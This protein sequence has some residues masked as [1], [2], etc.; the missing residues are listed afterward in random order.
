MYVDAAH[1]YRPSIMPTLLYRAWQPLLLRS[2]VNLAAI[3]GVYAEVDH[4]G[5]V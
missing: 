1:C 5:F 2:G 4:E 3:L